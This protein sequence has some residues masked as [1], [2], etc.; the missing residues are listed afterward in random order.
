MVLVEDNRDIIILTEESCLE[1]A[2]K[3]LCCDIVKYY[4]IKDNTWIRLVWN[5]T[6]SE[7]REINKY[8]IRASNISCNCDKI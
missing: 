5:I 2:Q 3:K 7:F 6:R 4:S 8:K 1:C